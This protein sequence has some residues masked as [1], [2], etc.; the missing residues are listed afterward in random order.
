LSAITAA[1]HEREL[2]LFLEQLIQFS[3]PA[4]S[5]IFN[6]SKTLVDRYSA[7]LANGSSGSWC[8]VDTGY[9]PTVCHASLYCL[10]AILAEG[11]AD[12]K[13]DDRNAD[14]IFVRVRGSSPIGSSV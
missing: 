10:P 14:S 4:E 6:N 7:A 11:E 9:L 2:Q 12:G 5:T 8:E 1:S 3:G 13:H